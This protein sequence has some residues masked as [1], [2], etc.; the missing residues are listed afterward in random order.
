MLS[1][2]MALGLLLGASVAPAVVSLS[3]RS[4]IARTSPQTHGT[5][6]H[7]GLTTQSL[8]HLSD[9]PFS[10][11][12]VHGSIHLQDA[13]GQQ[14]KQEPMW[15]NPF[16]LASVGTAMVVGWLAGSRYQRSFADSSSFSILATSGSDGSSPLPTF[17]ED[18]LP[19]ETLSQ[20][21][22]AEMLIKR[23]EDRYG[24][25]NVPRV[26]A[27]FRASNEGRRL[28]KVHGPHPL[29]VQTATSWIEGL[30]ATPVWPD[31]EKRF[32]WAKVL[33][34]EW[35]TIRDELQAVIGI[36][37][38]QL[39]AL[40]S[41]SWRP[42]PVFSSYGLG[43]KTLG[44]CESG[45][46]DEFNTAL[47]RKTCAL[48]RKSGVQVMQAF[49]AKMPGKSEIRPHSDETNIAITAQLGLIIPEN[50]CH[51][52]C[53]DVRH[54]WRNG[55]WIM[56][57]TSFIH[58]AYNESE[59]DRYVL[60]LRVWHPDLTPTEVEAMQFLFDAIDDPDL[61]LHPHGSMIYD[62]ILADREKAWNSIIDAS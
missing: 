8:R 41:V 17:P 19:A 29:M 55:E 36:G 39:E 16:W 33:Q 37:E 48:I 15:W 13:E 20:D 51:I 24:A 25:Q 54:D 58:E 30:C 18:G 53:G 59:K 32:V 52:N 31:P 61:V 57:D 10:P 5:R 44:L 28:R 1:G 60:I 6:I 4:F 2:A 34:D 12:H 43:W 22:F 42:H 27:S 56:M 11:G 9:L 45:L 21:E 7:V 47:F 35:Q 38:Q 14:S 46:W 23:L 26:V 62:M 40:G 50:E 3:F 49:F